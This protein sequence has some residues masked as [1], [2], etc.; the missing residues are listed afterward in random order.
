MP[1]N[2][3]RMSRIICQ[4][5]K[6]TYS[7]I[8]NKS[9]VLRSNLW[10]LWLFFYNVVLNKPVGLIDLVAM[11]LRNSVTFSFKL[12]VSSVK[13]LMRILQ[14]AKTSAIFSCRFFYIKPR[15]FT[16]FKLI[17]QLSQ[18]KYSERVEELAKKCSSSKDLNGWFTLA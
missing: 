12:K 4:R 15:F 17:T 5:S 11:E 16:P 2:A 14:S 7:S 1:I 10:V 9:S 8:L 13:S 18:F 6:I 3:M